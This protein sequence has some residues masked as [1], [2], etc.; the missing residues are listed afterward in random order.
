MDTFVFLDIIRNHGQASSSGLRG[1]YKE[2]NPPKC[3]K[4][5]LHAYNKLFSFQRK[6]TGCEKCSGGC[7]FFTPIIKEL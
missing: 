5:G 2:Y 4:L 7:G 1:D 6:I 3:P